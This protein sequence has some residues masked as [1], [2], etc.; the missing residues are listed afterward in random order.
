MPCNLQK[1]R[2]ASNCASQRL[3]RKTSCVVSKNAA[4]S[5]PCNPFGLGSRE[6]SRRRNP[7]DPAASD[8]SRL[9]VADLERLRPFVVERRLVELRRLEP[10]HRWLRTMRLL[11]LAPRAGSPCWPARC[12]A[13]LTQAAQGRIPSR[14]AKYDKCFTECLSCCSMA[15]G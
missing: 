15:D 6:L 13:S 14:Q 1:P 9:R 3:C 11:G 5:E 10:L 7:L 12:S 4:K 2:A 8:L